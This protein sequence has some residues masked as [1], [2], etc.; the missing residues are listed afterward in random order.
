MVSLGAE[1]ICG[2]APQRTRG[3]MEDHVRIT[4]AFE[5]RDSLVALDCS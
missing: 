4:A 5:I 3:P 1:S 2:I